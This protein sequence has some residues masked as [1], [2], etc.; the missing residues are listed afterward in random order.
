MDHPPTPPSRGA[1]AG[2]SNADIIHRLVSEHVDSLIASPA[3]AGLRY[4]ASYARKSDPNGDGIATQHEINRTFAA[5][6]GYVIPDHLCFG[7]DDTSGT[8]IRRKDWDR[9]QHAIECG[10]SSIEAVIVRNKARLGR[11]TDPGMHDYVRIHLQQLGVALLFVE[12]HNPDYARGLTPE[13][14]VASISDRMESISGSKEHAEIRRRVTTGV[15]RRVKQGYYPGATAPYGTERWLIN[16]YTGTLNERVPD[17]L[18]L[19]APDGAYKLRW[20]TE[21]EWRD[22][23]QLIFRLLVEED[24]GLAEISRQLAAKGYPAPG[25]S[26]VRRANRLKSGPP[27]WTA[28]AVSYILRNPIY[29]G[30]L[31]WGRSTQAATPVPH[32]EAAVDE[33]GPILFR[34]YMPDP[35]ISREVFE[36]VQRILRERRNQRRRVPDR[37]LYLLSGLVRCALCDA[38]WHGHTSTVQRARR[39]YYRHAQGR[40]SDSSPAS[41]PHQHRYV[42]AV[43]LE[44]AVV[45]R[46]LAMIE[47]APLEAAIKEEVS[48]RIEMYASKDHAAQIEH[49]ERDIVAHRK[50]ITGLL[51][52]SARLQDDTLLS[53][54]RIQLE[55][56]GAELRGL[57]QRLQD[58]SAERDHTTTALAKHAASLAQMTTLLGTYRHATPRRRTAI[59]REIIGH[60][61]FDPVGM[62]ADVH[63]RLP[64]G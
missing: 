30:D 47:T 1:A 12:G 43:D 48:R 17:G 29:A 55:H 50:L 62:S 57:Q 2:T 15:R 56:A 19:R 11:W 61:S 59:L 35:P 24:C 36:Q 28:T 23:V 38:R 44:A 26:T 22:A 39:R 46:V 45:P 4:A 18:R 41:C 8:T 63:V 52:E 31:H 20:R 5:R 3:Q 6:H 64:T 21:T 7:D 34:D 49:V 27:T 53:E 14:M 10:E 58:L 25:R 33:E 9:L 54:C 16:R 37:Q 32:S 40:G 13:A 42:R 51:R 60:I